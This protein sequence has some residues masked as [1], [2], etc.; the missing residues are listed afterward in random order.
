MSGSE[1]LASIDGRRARRD[2]NRETV[3]DA[4]L[5]LYRE[6]NV[7]PSL[8]EIAQRSEVSH[9]S[10]FRYFEDLEELYQVAI[11]RHYA[12]MEP[13]LQLEAEPAGD[14]D[15]RIDQF[16]AHRLALYERAAPVARVGRMHALRSDLLMDNLS[17]SRS[18]LRRQARAH[19]RPDLQALPVG[20]AD[21]VTNAMTM[22]LS[23]EAIET[24]RFHQGLSKSA[25]KAA[26][27]TAL[28][29]LLGPEAR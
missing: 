21:A 22:M 16:V 2:R 27:I 23:F 17:R 19:F 6:G 18:R 14:L 12:T 15:G 20:E 3:V 26:L 25:T 28:T 29:R 5:S 10:V 11:E 13:F 7:A 1:E 4:I 9:R 8:D 24:M